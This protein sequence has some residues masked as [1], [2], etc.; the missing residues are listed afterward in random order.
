MLPPGTGFIMVY[1]FSPPEFDESEMQDNKRM[2]QL[3]TIYLALIII[4]DILL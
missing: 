4:K 1:M 2:G 3:R